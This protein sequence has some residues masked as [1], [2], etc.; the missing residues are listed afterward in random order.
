VTDPPL[1][2]SLLNDSS[3]NPYP[4]V[5]YITCNNFSTS[6]SAFLTTI[7]K[8]VKPRHYKDAIKDPRWRQAMTE[9]IYAL[10]D[11]QAWTIEDWPPG[12]KSIRSK[13]VSKVK[14]KSDGAIK[15]FEARLVVRSNHQLEGF[16][17]NETFSL[18]AKMSTVRTFLLIAVA[19]GW[20]LHQME[21][22]NTFLYGDLDEEVFMWLPLG[23]SSGSP[24]KRCVRQQRFE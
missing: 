18:V 10:E 16:D 13:R 2:S 20:E 8:I 17:F 4:L 3:G 14:Y 12:K 19:K 22:D 6:H 15:R 11:N 23:F 24:T 7:T 9:E 1:S 5:H 21:D